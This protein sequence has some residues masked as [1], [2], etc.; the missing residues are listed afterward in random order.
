VVAG[1]TVVRA[2]AA[3]AG[4]GRYADLTRLVRARRPLKASC[5]P[6]AVAVPDQGRPEAGQS[7][8]L[9]ADETGDAKSTTDC[10]GVGRPYSGAIGGVGPP[11]VA[12]HLGRSPRR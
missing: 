3:S 9:V 7:V 1:I 8:V 6:R 5:R 12:V 10:V 11:Q 2:A 4:G